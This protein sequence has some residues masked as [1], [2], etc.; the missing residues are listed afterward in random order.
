MPVSHPS[1]EESHW[2]DP[3]LSSPVPSDEPAWPDPRYQPGAE[4]QPVA[5][6]QPGPEYPPVAPYQPA[7]Y[8]GVP[9][10]PGYGPA[11]PY[12]VAPRKSRTGRT[13]AIVVSVVVVIALACVGGVVLAVVT[14]AKP[15]KQMASVTPGQSAT[16]GPTVTATPSPSDTLRAHTGDL[17]NFLLTPPATSRPAPFPLSKNGLLTIKQDAALSGNPAARIAYLKRFH[18]K[19]EAVVAWHDTEDTLVN[20]RLLQF[21]S[22]ENAA[23]YFSEDIAGIASEYTSKNT[24]TIAGVPGGRTFATPKKDKYG[25]TQTTSFATRGDVVIVMFTLQIPPLSVD[26]ANTLVSKQY[27]KL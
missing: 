10:N 4:Y 13:I 1:S 9:Y 20:I 25:Y 19:R 23:N 12:P 11:L 5:P 16:A 26:I 3:P 14:G 7:G 6:Y 2:T 21:S 27:D 17:R 24:H 18:F 8:P 15:A 22:A